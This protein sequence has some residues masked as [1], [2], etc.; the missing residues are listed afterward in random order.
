MRPAPHTAVVLNQVVLERGPCEAQPPARTDAVE[1]FGDMGVRILDS[2]ACI[3]RFA[4][5]AAGVCSLI[6]RVGRTNGASKW[7][8]KNPN[9]QKIRHAPSMRQTR[10]YTHTFVHNNDVRTRLLQSFRE[11]G[12][13]R[14]LDCRRGE[15]GS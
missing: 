3:F 7:T 6:K 1:H 11:K 4:R 12:F 9:R 5:R 15:H 2:M 8:D 13:E 10:A 14:F